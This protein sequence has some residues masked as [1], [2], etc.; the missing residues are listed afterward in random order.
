MSKYEAHM[1][2]MNAGWACICGEIYVKGGIEM[3]LTDKVLANLDF[4]AGL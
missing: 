1:K 2:L 4:F 3:R